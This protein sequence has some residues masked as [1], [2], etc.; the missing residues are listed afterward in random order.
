MP[1]VF[2]PRSPYGERH[3]GN[4]QRPAAANFNP[5]SPCGATTPPFSH[6]SYAV[7]QSTSPCG[8]RLGRRVRREPRANFNPRPPCGERLLNFH[9]VL[10]QNLF[11]STLPVWGATEVLTQ[12]TG[13]DVISIHAPR[14]GSDYPLQI[15]EEVFV[16]ISI[17]APR[18]GSD[19]PSCF[20]YTTFYISI[21]A[22]R[23]GSDPWLFSGVVSN[24]VFQSTLPVWGATW[25]TA[26]DFR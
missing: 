15:F 22:P 21:H 11:Q 16:F 20:R 7:F 2:N 12:Y 9:I 10:L 5:R 4:G 25:S 8:E 6:S 14:V 24:S 23:V 26:L 13:T 17:H 1:T 19:Y 18:V 3:A